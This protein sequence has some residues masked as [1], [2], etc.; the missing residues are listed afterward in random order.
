MAHRRSQPRGPGLL[1]RTRRRAV[2]GR[3]P[4]RARGRHHPGGAGPRARC[5]PHRR[6]ASPGGAG[7]T[8]VLAHTALVVSL[9]LLVP[10]LL[11]V[12]VLAAV[13]W[14]DRRSPDAP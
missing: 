8:P 6:P 12:V 10:P 4:L 1:A 11:A 5:A 2:V 13:V 9:P 3:R 7:M 14:R